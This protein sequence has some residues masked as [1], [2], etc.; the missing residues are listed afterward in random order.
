MRSLR[1]LLWR[2]GDHRILAA[3]YPV[4]LVVTTTDPGDHV[5]RLSDQDHWNTHFS[6]LLVMQ[7]LN[8]DVLSGGCEDFAKA[9]DEVRMSLN[10]CFERS[11]LT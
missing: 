7:F 5:A 2:I 6:G 8:L 9:V 11:A 3:S 4:I 1:W 10:E